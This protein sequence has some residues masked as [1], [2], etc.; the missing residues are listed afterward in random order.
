[1]TAALKLFSA[2]PEATFELGRKLGAILEKGLFIA[3][4]GELGGGKTCFT[5]GIVAGA[6][7][8]SSHLVAS[9]TFAIMNEYPGPAPLYHFD[10]YRLVNG[11]EI[12]ELGF[13][14]YF[15]GQGVCIVEWSDRL[16]DLLPADRL[17]ITFV[18]AGDDR[19]QITIEASGTGSLALLQRF[20]REIP[21]NFFDL[22][23]IGLL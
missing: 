18:N 9:P 22:Q 21:E 3:L 13:E 10:F 15:H 4:K 17:E 1:M 19:R 14:E 23:A 6:A 5:R 2:S 20:S 16:G 12:I 8:E 7:P 11:H